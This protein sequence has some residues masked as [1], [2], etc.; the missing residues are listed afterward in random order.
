MAD[1]KILII[2]ASGFIGNKLYRYF[3]ENKICV[4]GTYFSKGDN[5]DSEDKLYLDLRNKNIEEIKKLKNL[6]HV[7]FCHG[8]SDVEVCKEKKALSYAVNV[9][10]SINLLKYCKR[11]NIL[12]VYLST[13]MVFDGES[14]LPTEADDLTPVS[15]YGKQKLEVEKFIIDNFSKYIILRLTKVFGVEPCDNTLFTAWLDKLMKK[16]KIRA[17][18]DVFISPV[19]VMD[20]LNVTNF[21]IENS[22]SG[23]YNLG[24]CETL[25]IYDF[26]KRLA[27]FF[28]YDLT[29]IKEVSINDFSFQEKRPK[30]NSVDSAKVRRDSGVKLTAIDDC[31]KLIANNYRISVN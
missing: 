9:A 22:H 8:I 27:A 11:L 5:L 19:Y 17:A 10:N 6:R 26:A 1:R 15:E 18:S 31:F 25:R 4:K 20:V 28:N 7:I 14:E 2:G 21:L 13:S 12:P 30:F 24:G 16:E 29:C 3:K 23:V